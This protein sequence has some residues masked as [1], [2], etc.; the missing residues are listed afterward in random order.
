MPKEIVRF[1]QLRSEG[2]N[3]QDSPL[4][5]SP[6]LVKVLS[7]RYNENAYGQVEGKEHEDSLVFIS[8]SPSCRAVF[9]QVV[10]QLLGANGGEYHKA[11][12]VLW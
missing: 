1:S 10:R 6:G 5:E 12:C 7:S 9:V 4:K 8:P 11:R 3:D 2:R